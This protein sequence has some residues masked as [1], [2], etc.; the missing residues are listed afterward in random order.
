MF[1]S[2]KLRLTRFAARLIAVSRSVAT[3]F[4]VAFALRRGFG[5][6]GRRQHL[7]LIGVRLLPKLLGNVQG[8]DLEPNWQ[9]AFAGE[10]S[11]NVGAAESNSC[12]TI[13]SAIGRKGNLPELVLCVSNH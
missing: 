5:L 4:S 10:V 7:T 11:S 2:L 8:V 9:A 6:W 13:R 1:A 12:K 3:C